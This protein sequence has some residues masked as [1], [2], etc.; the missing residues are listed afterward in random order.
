MSEF[1]ITADTE[2]RL[3]RVTTTGQHSVEGALALNLAIKRACKEH[4]IDR[5]LC[6]LHHEPTQRVFAFEQFHVI[7]TIGFDPATRV[8]YVVEDEDECRNYELLCALINRSKLFQART[9]MD[10]N[11]A[12]S[13]L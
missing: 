4:T 12:E 10:Q 1:A 6:Q 13:W 5:V 9:F 2:D 7:E 3:L 8:A 11:E